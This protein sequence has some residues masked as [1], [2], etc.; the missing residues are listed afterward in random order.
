MGQDRASRIVAEPVALP[1]GLTRLQTH[2]LEQFTQAAALK[3][4][5]AGG[6]DA[7]PTMRLLDAILAARYRD[8]AAQRVEGAADVILTY[9]ASPE[10]GVAPARS[11]AQPPARFT[12]HP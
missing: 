5:M 7:E 6:K 4:V 1:Q 11:P 2:V 8:C 10:S 9:V 12:A 3:Q